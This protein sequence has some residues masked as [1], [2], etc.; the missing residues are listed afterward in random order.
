[1]RDRAR[2]V[3]IGGGVGGASILYWLT[4]LGWDDV[5]LVERADLTSG[6]TFHSAGLVGQLRGSLSL[7][8]MMMNSVDLYRT[9]ADE[10]GLETGWHEVGSLRLASSQ[11]RME[12]LA[13][14]AGWAKTFGLPLEL[15]SAE[16]AQRLFP[17]MSDRRRARRRLPADGRLHR[18]EPAHVRA[19]RGRPPRRRRDRDAHARHRDRRRARPRHRRRDGQGPGRGRGGRQRRRHVRRR[20]RPPGRRQRPGDPDGARVPDHEAERRPARRADD[21]RPLAPRL[22]PRR[23]RRARHGRLRAPPGAVGPRRHPARLQRAAPRGGLGAL[24]GADDER[25]RARP[26]ARGGRG[27]EARQRA[28]RRS[29]RTASSSSARATSAASGSRPASARTGSRARAGWGKLV[30]EWIVEGVPS[31]DVWEMDSRR[32]GAAYTSR[33]YTLARTVEV[34]STYYDVKYPGHEREA[35]RP[36]RVSPAYERLQELGAAFGEKS[37]WERAN[38]FE[39]NA[40][41]GDESLRPR[42]W[43]GRLWSPAIGAEHRA[44]RETAALFD[45][46]SFAK[47]DVAGPGAAGFL[48]SA[49]RQPRR[50]RRRSRHLH[51]DAEPARRHRVRLHRH[52]A[53][54]G[55]L[56]HRHRHRLRPARL[57]LDPRARAGRRLRAR[58]GRHLPLRLPRPLGPGRARAPAAAHRRRPRQ[59]GVPVHARAPAQH[60]RRPVSG[61]ARDVRRRARLG[62]LLP[63]GVRAP[64]LGHPLGGG[65]R[66]R[67]RRRRLQGDR[68]LAAREGLPRLGRRHH[69]GRDART[70]PASAS[71]SSSTR[72][73]S[74]GATRSSPRRSSRSSG[75]S[76]ASSSTSRAR[77]RSAPSPCGWTARSSA[78]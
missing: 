19:R 51:A 40:E 68:L 64:P 27:R 32:F 13:R 74:S 73:T 10:V 8:R 55:A 49:L 6:S 14:Q 52:A 18:P 30:A 16:E 7:T 50:A 20:D 33:S 78:G 31:L 25:D 57:R 17:P 77:S 71:P 26:G 23:V 45:E 48:E 56:P 66:A 29:R 41:R 47:L 9:L 24:R 22:L 54:G 4:K 61:R 34:Y 67:P 37:G 38:W 12:E 65:P 39:P 53:R 70:R 58:R 60:R 69:A 43:A 75:G 5:L 11:E 1:M 15:V 59:R 28:R 62:A 3:V 36:L 76:P 21:A 46:T 2:A 72:A 44:C 63:D 42:G 35:G